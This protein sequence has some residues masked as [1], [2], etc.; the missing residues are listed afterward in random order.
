[1]A[2]S[3][4]QYKKESF[5]G[6]LLATT[7]LLINWFFYI[8]LNIIAA[9]LFLYK[10]FY[11]YFGKDWIRK[12]QIAIFLC[13]LTIKFKQKKLKMKNLSTFEMANG[14]S[15]FFRTTLAMQVQLQHDGGRPP[16]FL[17]SGVRGLL[18]SSFRRRRL[19][20]CVFLRGTH[21][22]PSFNFSVWINDKKKKKKNL[23]NWPRAGM[24]LE[25]WRRWITS[26][27]DEFLVCVYLFS[28]NCRL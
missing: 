10:L 5:T 12:W 3:S 6:N 26:P 13:Y 14:P 7:A 27:I 11:L 23:L 25:D 20:L 21:T 18:L 16:I 17:S 15:D 4:S 28:R 22:K 24:Q 8:N 9:G 19:L 2:I 1:M